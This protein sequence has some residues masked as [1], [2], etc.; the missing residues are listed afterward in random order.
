MINLIHGDSSEVLKTFED[1]SI[2]SIVTDLVW[3]RIPN[4]PMYFINQK[5]D[6][7]GLHR[8]IIKKS[9]LCPKGYE[10]IRLSCKGI[11][12]TKS[13]HRLVAKCFL[14]DYSDDLQVN[15]INC[16]KNDNRVCNLEMVTQNQNT[17]HAWDND[18]MKLT[19]KGPNG[20]FVKKENND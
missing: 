20:K 17:K 18:R 12:K 10:K 13:V 6:I 11:S 19:K 16:I 1:N 3:K 4:Y 2:D 9:G 5:G 14:S 7:Y 8:K 15:H